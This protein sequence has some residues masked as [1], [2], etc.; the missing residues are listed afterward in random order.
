M[1]RT[2]QE[3]GT[4]KSDEYAES[5]AWEY[6][7]PALLGLGSYLVFQYIQSGLQAIDRG[8]ATRASMIYDA[9]ESAITDALK[10]S[11][12]I[13]SNAYL[14]GLS[15]PTPGHDKIKSR[16]LD[17]TL[18]TARYL[19]DRWGKT[20][21]NR[22][23]LHYQNVRSAISSDLRRIEMAKDNIERQLTSLSRMHT[24]SSFVFFMDAMERYGREMTGQNAL[25]RRN[26]YVITR[27]IR[28][29]ARENQGKTVPNHMIG[30]LESEVRAGY[31][32]S[33][34]MAVYNQINTHLTGNLVRLVRNVSNLGYQ[35]ASLRFFASNPRINAV[36]WLLSPSHKHIDMC[37]DFAMTDNG[38]G[39]GVWLVGFSPYPAHANC[40][41]TLVPVWDVVPTNIDIGQMQDSIED[42][43]NAFYDR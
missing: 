15:S 24:R 43:R 4:E 34:S 13:S 7:S 23:E 38:M 33:V 29:W 19:P 2:P 12:E 39:E 40:M 8:L 31:S 9:V 25:G 22:A 36:K 37:D 41:C 35:D 17:E 20:Y 16:V 28:K 3:E 42:I 26:F 14:R 11:V 27:K 10:N 6:I 18:L 1:E 5:V 21:R 32:G 30:Q